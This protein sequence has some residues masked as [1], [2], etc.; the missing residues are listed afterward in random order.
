MKSRLKWANHVDR[1]EDEKLPE[2]MHRKW[3]EKGGEVDREC[4]EVT[5]LRE[6]WKEWVENGEQQRK[7]LETVDRERNERKEKDDANHG[8]RHS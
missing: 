2:Q 6:I 3:R 4:D 7:E 8:Q 1:M 5:A